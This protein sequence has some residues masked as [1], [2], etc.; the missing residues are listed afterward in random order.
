MGNVY[1]Y[2]R[3]IAPITVNARDAKGVV[4]FTK[5]F[6]PERTDV[7]TGRIASTGYLALTE[8]EYRQLSESSRTFAHYKDV[9]GLLSASDDVPPGAKTPQEALADARRKEREAGGRIAALEAENR[10][11][12]EGLADADKRIGQLVSAS[13]PEE[14]LKPLQDKIASLEEAVKELDALKK[15]NEDLEQ[16]FEDAAKEIDA[17]KKENEALKQGRAEAGGKTG[18]APK[19]GG[20]GKGKEFD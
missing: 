13:A 1:I 7:T 11:L 20:G 8:E 12:K 9:L 15:E 18:G 2:N 14:A 4:I 10:K 6:E 16:G 3:H 5:R 17:L 19:A